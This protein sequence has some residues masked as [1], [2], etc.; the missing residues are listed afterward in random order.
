M[1]E[2][3]PRSREVS[4]AAAAD[5]AR[6]G[7]RDATV[8]IVEHHPAWAARFTA[9][10]E[11]LAPLLGDAEVHHIGSTAVP[12]LAAKAVIDLMALV[13]DVEAPVQTLVQ[14]GGYVFP[15]AFNA[16]LRDRR[17]LCRPSAAQ[18]THHLHLVAQRAELERHLHF[19]DRL[20][21][22]P[23]LAA[24][25]ATLKRELAARFPDDRERYSEAKGAFVRRVVEA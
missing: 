5:L 15:E 8:E 24:Q 6:A 21:A 17:W 22:D 13:G 3:R 10:R 14:R 11:R 7:S 25:Y 16:T 23:G 9:E 20:R 12:G 19:R 18:R 1:A 2:D 4:E